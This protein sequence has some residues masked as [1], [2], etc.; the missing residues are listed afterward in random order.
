[1]SRPVVTA[2][3]LDELR[4]AGQQIR[5]PKN[6]LITPAAKDWFRDQ[7]VTIQWVEEGEALRHSLA[8][9]LDPAQPSMRAVMAMLEKMGSFEVIPPAATGVGPLASAV[10]RLCGKV[11]RREVT[12]GI[13]F[14]PDAFLPMVIANKHHGVRAILGTCLPA[15]QNACREMAANVLV[16]DTSHHAAYQTRQMIERLMAGPTAPPAEISATLEALERSGGR[17]DW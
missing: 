6:A 14:T 13:V 17:E 2:L 4:R 9:V 7:R 16:I 8:V 11:H 15:V 3:L 1:M 5:L 12:K 10:R